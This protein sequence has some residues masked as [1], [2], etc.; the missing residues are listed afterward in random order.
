[1]RSDHLSSP[2]LYIVKTLSS[3][4]LDGLLRHRLGNML[5][6]DGRCSIF[7]HFLMHD[8]DTSQATG[9][10][11]AGKRHLKLSFGLI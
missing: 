8:V 10:N 1:M 9:F 6:I 11:L 5:D 4:L 7:G 2:R 3:S